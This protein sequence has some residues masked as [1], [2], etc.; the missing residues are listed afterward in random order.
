[1]IHEALAFLL[2]HMPPQMHLILA[3][4]ADP[5]LPLARWR[6][7]SRLVELRQQDLRFTPTEAA[8]FLN[9][10]MT[11]PL[12]ADDVQ[13]L[14]TRTE[15]WIAGLQM[16][17]VSLQGR[18]D[19]AEFVQSFGGSHRYILDY[20]MEEVL[21]RLPEEVTQFLLQTA[22]LDRLCAPLCDAVLEAGD[23]RLETTQFPVSN[24]Q[25]QKVLERLET[26]NLF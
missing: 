20:L 15:G 21:A 22:V 6:A 18:S 14:T 9:R 7:R 5:P 24:L 12:S 16:A 11:L 25:S 3:S 1:A 10:V 23:R 2:E 17:A 4:R 19:T 26:A 13:T 8:D